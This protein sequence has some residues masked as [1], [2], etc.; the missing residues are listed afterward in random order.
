[1]FKLPKP[2]KKELPLE[3]ASQSEYNWDVL[4]DGQTYDLKHGEHFGCKVGTFAQMARN[5]A[6]KRFL[7]LRVSVDEEAGTVSIRAFPMTDE[8]KVS[9]QAKIDERKAEK[10][11]ERELRKAEK[12]AA[13]TA[14]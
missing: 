10:Q 2:S 6:K 14:A 13:T 1:M 11:A 3:T 5:Q 7:N 12:E 8:Q 4:L 9:A